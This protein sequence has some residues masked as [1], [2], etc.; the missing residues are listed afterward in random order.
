MST[1]LPA[2][3]RQS[4]AHDDDLLTPHDIVE[5]SRGLINS[6]TLERWR[7]TG[8]GPAFVKVGHKVA[9]R[10]RDYRA[11]LDARTRTHTGQEIR[12]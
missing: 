12:G 8:Q 4:T 9:Y 6:R 3:T 10:R 2:D 5:E 11:W 1:P 7:S